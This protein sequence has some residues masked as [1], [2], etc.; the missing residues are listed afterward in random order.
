[1][2][3]RSVATELSRL[4][5]SS[6]KLDL[7]AV[8]ATSCPD[9][10]RA[11]MDAG[12]WTPDQLVHLDLSANLIDTLPEWFTRL[13]ALMHLDLNRNQLSALPAPLLSLAHLSTLLLR[14]NNVD[15]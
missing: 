6:K 7:C 2:S 1:M 14:G 10:L 8:G 4:Q 9:E 5:Q 12:L 15:R 3:E 11:L 13:H